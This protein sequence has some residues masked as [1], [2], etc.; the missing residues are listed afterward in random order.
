MLF[1]DFML[2]CYQIH[3]VA[4]F[5]RWKRRQWIQLI[6][7]TWRHQ[8]VFG[9]VDGL[10]SRLETVF[11][12]F[13]SKNFYDKRV[14]TFLVVFLNNSPHRQKLLRSLASQKQRSTMTQKRISLQTVAIEESHASLSREIIH[15]RELETRITLLGLDLN[16]QKMISHHANQ[17]IQRLSAIIEVSGIHTHIWCYHSITMICF[18]FFSQWPS[19]ILLKSNI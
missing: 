11:V 1:D 9:R 19:S 7:R 14:L 16:R 10:Y 12:F 17:E 4:S 18:Y 13:Q 2:V 3:I 5:V 8:A 6:L 15:T